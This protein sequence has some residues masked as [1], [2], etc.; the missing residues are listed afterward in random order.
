MDDERLTQCDCCGLMKPHCTD[1]TGYGLETHA[2]LS[3]RG[4]EEDAYD[5]GDDDEPSSP[6]L[7]TDRPP[8]PE[9]GK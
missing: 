6:T 8:M 4:I 2:C 7:P 9:S 5:D 1:L 3:C